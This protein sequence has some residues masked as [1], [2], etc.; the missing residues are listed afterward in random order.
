[1]REVP[2]D[3]NP[4]AL[5]FAAAL[6]RGDVDVA[7]F[8][9]GVGTRILMQ[10]IATVCPKDRFAA[11]LSKVKVVAR[12]PKPLAVL[13]EL[14]VPVWV[15]APE[16]NTWHEVLSAID[17]AAGAGGLK[18]VRVAVQ[19]YGV[20][21]EE[22]MD[23]LR[24][25]GARVTAVPIYQWALPEDIEPL[26]NAVTA[27]VNGDVDVVLFTTR[28]QVAH[29]CQIAAELG[30]ADAL[31]AGL[32][33]LVVA[34]IGPTTSEEL[35]HRGLPVD[36]EPSHAKLGYLVRET[37]ERAAGLLATRRSQA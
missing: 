28:I 14:S 2:L 35:R 19:E 31:A 32:R 18:G 6:D 3:A 7:I 36:I 11:A 27:I 16:P 21:N 30:E 34:S 5:E 9:T 26:R 33:R 13:H 37:A 23:G 1:M 20:S 22:L 15:A 25:R 12:G 8:L 24:Q 17:A 4:V 29:L 10:A